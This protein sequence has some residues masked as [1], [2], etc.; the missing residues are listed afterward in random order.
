MIS[1]RDRLL[2]KARGC[3]ELAATAVTPE[4]RQILG[5]IASRYEQEAAVAA[6]KRERRAQTFFA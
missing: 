3:H 5:E 1:E 6:A 4:G 2:E